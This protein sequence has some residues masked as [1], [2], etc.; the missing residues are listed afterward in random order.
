MEHMVYIVVDMEDTLVHKVADKVQ[1]MVQ[2]HMLELV[3]G[4]TFHHNMVHHRHHNN[5][6]HHRRHMQVHNMVLH[7]SLLVV[8]NILAY[9]VVLVIVRMACMGLDKGLDY[10]DNYRGH[11]VYYKDRM[12]H[13]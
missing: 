6:L 3:E 9:R 1:G 7:N 5:Y 8:G 13:T 11:R 2:V 10:M 12:E 4:H